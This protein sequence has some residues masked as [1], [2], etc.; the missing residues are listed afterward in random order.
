MGAPHLSPTTRLGPYEV[1]GPIGS[2]GMGEVYRARDTRLDR[3]V[4]VKVLP[5][6]FAA[7]EQRRA[8]FEREAKAISSLN[9]P[10]ICSLYDVGHATLDGS[11]VH[12]LVLELIEG[13]SLAHRLVRGP[14]P[15][16]LLLSCAA[17]IASA[18]DAA[19]RKGIVHR[20][21]KPSNVMLTKSGAKLVD[22]GLARL[23]E[24]EGVTESV[25]APPLGEDPLTETG[26][27]L[28]TFRYMAPEQLEGHKA[29]AR[30]DI[31]AFGTLL[32]EMA[33]G[34]KAFVGTTRSGLIAAILSSQPPPISG[35]Q[36]TSPPTLDHV[37]RQCLEKDPDDRWQSAR[38]VMSEVQWIAAMGSKARVA[39]PTV[40]PRKGREGITWWML[41]IL[42]AATIALAVAYVHKAPPGAAVVRFAIPAPKGISDM[43][44][45]RISPDGRS[46]AFNAIDAS[47]RP[48]LWLRSLEAL[49]ARPLPG[50]E[51]SGRPF[52]SPDS[53]YIGFMAGGK[54]KKIDVTGGVPQTI[55]DAPTGTDG[56]WSASGV[57]LFDGKVSEDPIRRVSASGGVARP[58]VMPDPAKGIGVG[59]PV[60]LPGG[61][62]FLFVAGRPGDQDRQLMLGTLD[63]KEVRPLLNGRAIGHFEYAPPGYLLYAR[64]QTLMAH[65]FDP[66]ALTLKG[67]PVPL[68]EGV[69]VAGWNSWLESDFSVSQSGVLVHTA[70]V[71][72]AAELAW[73]DRSGRRLGTLGDP[74]DYSNPA[75]S[76]DEKS[77]AVGRVSPGTRTRD[78]WVL[79]LVRGTNKRLTFDPA[80]DL[81]ATW[82]PDGARIAFTS[83]RKGVRQI[84]LKR[85]DGSGDDELLL[86]SKA[87]TNAED[88]SPDG[89]FLLYNLA[90][91]DLYLLPM[92]S[93][94]DRRPLPFLATEMVESMGRFAPNGR[95]IA[96]RS[97]ESGR[98][99]IYVR[100][101]SPDGLSAGGKWQVSTAGGL[102]PQWRHDGRE[103]FYLSGSRTV[104]MSVD[105]KTDGP[106]FEV[107]T[108]KPLFEV[109]LVTAPRRNRYV[110]S[111]DGQRFL[112]VARPEGAA[113]MT[114]VL[115][116]TAALGN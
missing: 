38:D 54:L 78:I 8:R 14:L 58:E 18:L 97:D 87:D 114:V 81:N 93:S 19:H 67:E 41:A 51:G 35:M 82:S 99:E 25:S 5:A 6:A 23:V 31:F 98:D 22:F 3:Q 106:A 103:L 66:E 48:Q 7:N 37:V 49:E 28:G 105:V 89:R 107:G 91:S 90:T 20:D 71:A 12:Y 9:H 79:D 34:Q 101:L 17:Q 52:W 73:L 109:R 69:E 45:P 85:A 30:T 62:R 100:S 50:T 72:A 94:G 70:S 57:I 63:S 15:T 83:N 4:A 60:F 64:N 44:S 1:L 77:L 26:T 86:A 55:C 47:G 16:P 68:A 27:I 116:W 24:E 46:V 36:P 84:Y 40:A 10:N 32:Y 104:L 88:W 95:W 65:P 115:N 43:G 75:L 33:T 102:E 29:D 96:Y 111:R 110:V 53:R 80:D 108:P 13:E 76:P 61:R 2:G 113:P 56:T 11:D 92:S 42:G 59:W 39:T 74:G 21:L 112:T